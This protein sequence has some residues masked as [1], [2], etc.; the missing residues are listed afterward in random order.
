MRQLNIMN[1]RQG[2]LGGHQLRVRE[3]CESWSFHHKPELGVCV[4]GTCAK[5]F[6]AP[7]G[8]LDMNGPEVVLSPPTSGILVD[9]VGVECTR[10][11]YGEVRDS[12]GA[13]D[14]CDMFGRG[15]ICGPEPWLGGEPVLLGATMPPTAPPTDAPM[16]IMPTTSVITLHFF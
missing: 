16:T 3:V 1:L 13:T 9:G 7:V 6:P 11:T 10:E 2:Q 15:F 12:E 5:P 8:S 4:D 14:E